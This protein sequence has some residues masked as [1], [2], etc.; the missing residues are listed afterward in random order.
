MSAAKEPA[1][2]PQ[3]TE[4]NAPAFGEGARALLTAAAA[5]AVL[6]GLKYTREFTLPIILAAFLAIISYPF[7]H[8][9]RSKIH[10]PHWLAVTC[11]VFLDLGIISG[12]YFLISKLVASVHMTVQDNL[13]QYKIMGKYNE[14]L[15]ALDEWGGIGSQ[16]KEALAS[17][18]TVINAQ[19]ILLFS[20]SLTS[21][22]LSFMSV[23]AL[24]LI[25]MTFLLGEAPLFMR[26]FNR[27]PNSMQ[28]K[29][30]V[31]SAIK[32]VQKYLLIKTIASISTGI[33]AGLLCSFAGVP[34]AFLWGVVA[35]TLNFIPT[36]GSIVAAIPPVLLTLV[37]GDWGTTLLVAGGYL[38]IN[39]AIGN[40]IEPL[41]LGRQFGIATS[42]VL[43]S[44]I[45]WGW[46][47]GAVG[48]L[49]A[50]PITVLIKLALENSVD[51]KWIA[52]IIDNYNPPPDSKNV[53]NQ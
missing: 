13:W 38:A 15:Q 1:N 33:L 31:I 30:K 12:L 16:L 9:L 7:T 47:W 23:T 49:L 48:A 52:S 29:S 21:K 40:C 26:N 45:L 41:F 46:V 24:V 39:G 28:G 37:M 42:V 20:Q 34:F 2:E 17:P 25:L 4:Q 53:S 11:S 8:F 19:S 5:F 44:V 14:A 50:V 10:L 27:L 18:F 6:F 3:S 22:I 35:G 32:G 51:L 43:L 36:I